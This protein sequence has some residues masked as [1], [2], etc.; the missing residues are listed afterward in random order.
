M[1]DPASG[2]FAF[3]GV[4]VLGMGVFVLGFASFSTIRDSDWWVVTRGTARGRYDRL[5]RTLGTRRG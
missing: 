4:L 5:R 1:S 2:V 3:P